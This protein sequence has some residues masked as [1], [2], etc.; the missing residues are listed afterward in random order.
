MQLVCMVHAPP[1][2]TQTRL[3]TLISDGC[4]VLWSAVNSTQIRNI[5]VVSSA[6]PGPAR[7]ACPYPP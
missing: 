4:A 3:Q 7:P 2:C 6:S 1:S 5:G